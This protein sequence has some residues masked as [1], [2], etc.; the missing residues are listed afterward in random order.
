M[1]TRVT[2]DSLRADVRAWVTAHWDPSLSLRAWRERLLDAG[3][4][5]PSWPERWYGKGLPAW[6]DDVVRREL[7]S[8]RRSGD[9]SRRPRRPDDPRAGSRP[10]ARAVPAPAAD[11]RGGVVPAVQRAVGRLGPRRAHHHGGARR[12]RV[13]RQRPEGVEHQRAPRRPRDAPRSHRLG[14]AQ[15]PGHHLLR[16]ADAP[17]RRRGPPA[18]ADELPRV[19]QRGVPHRRTHPAG[20]GGRRGEPG[21]DRGAGHAGARAALRGARPVRVRRDG[22]STAPPSTRPRPRPQRSPRSTRGTRSAPGVSTSWS[23]TPGPRASTPTRVVRQEIARL[24]SMHRASEWTAERREGGTQARPAA[25]RR[26]LDRQARAEQ[27]RPPGG[28]GPSR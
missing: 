19:V 2:E 14:R 26:G 5:V 4:A 15:A 25:G 16:A 23:T 12:R 24:L 27:R 3:W 18:A 8:V 9:R 28:A 1:S 21:M 20:L 11:R 7:A 10:R 17:A 22:R 13:G 6:A